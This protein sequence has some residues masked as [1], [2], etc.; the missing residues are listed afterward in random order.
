V[1]VGQEAGYRLSVASALTARAFLALD[2]G[3]LDGAERHFAASITLYEAIGSTVFADATRA[4]SGILAR[5]RGDTARAEVLLLRGLEQARVLPNRRDEAFLLGELALLAV[6][7]G[8]RQQAAQLQAEALALWRTLEHEPGIAAASSWLAATWADAGAALAETEALIRTALGLAARHRLAPTALMTFVS[9]ASHLAA[10]GERTTPLELLALAEGHP[11]ATFETRR[12]AAARTAELGVGMP[13]EEVA[14]AR[15]RGVNLDWRVLAQRF[16]SDPAGADTRHRPTPT[17]LDTQL[18]P[19][20]GRDYE[21]GQIVGLLSGSARRLITL[22]GPGGIGKTRLAQEAALAMLDSYADGV[23]FVALAPIVDPAQLVAAIAEP[24]GLRLSGAGEPRDQLLRLLSPKQ[25]LLLLDNFEQLLEGGELIPAILH[26]APKVTVLVTTRER[27]GLDGE[28]VYT[29]GGIEI[30]AGEDD[31][32]AMERGAVQ[33]LLERVRQIRPAFDPGPRDLDAMIRICQLVQGM[34]LALILAAS[35]ADMLSLREI[36]AEIERCLDFLEAD[37]R[38]LPPRQRSV[39][40]VFDVSWRRLTPMA[41][42]CFARMS[43]FRGGF[44]RHAAEQIVGTDLRMLRSLI[45]SSFIS[46]DRDNRYTVHEL[47]RQF[48][49]EHVVALGEAEALRDRHSIYYLDLLRDLEADLRRRRQAEAFQT[50]ESDLDNIRQAWGRAIE[51]QAGERISQAAHAVLLFGDKRGRFREG[52]DLL[53]QALDRLAPA[54]ADAGELWPRLTTRLS[55]LRSLFP[56]EQQVPMPE[57]E[58]CLALAQ[59]AGQVFEEALAY[60]ALGMYYTR[61]ENDYGQA[62]AQFEPAL[63]LLRALDDRF[64]LAETLARYGICRGYT[65]DIPG[66]YQYCREGCEIA[67]ADENGVG[68][69]IAQGNLMEALLHLGRY[70]EVAEYG[71]RQIALGEQLGARNGVAHALQFIALARFLEGD[72]DAA[73]QTAMRGYTLGAEI[74]N[75]SAMGTCLSILGLQASVSGDYPLGRRFA[76][77]A[78]AQPLNLL[79]LVQAHLGDAIARRGLGAH[80]DARRSLDDALQFARRFATSVPTLWLLP[81]AALLLADESHPADAATLLGLAHT[82]ELSPRGWFT[83]WRALAELRAGLEKALAPEEF[84]AAW[85]RGTQLEPAAATALLEAH[86]TEQP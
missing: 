86:V 14:A 12:R 37:L 20:I 6:D 55:L 38:A 13:P 56:R 41:Q 57:V 73:R 77:E 31:E 82:H 48:G 68:V 54:P 74:Q 64:H 72:L 59:Q 40:A 17:N 36:A 11:A 66:F 15:Q 65:G 75:A 39:R 83:R 84:A 47:L 2:V 52:A 24:L 33:L 42:V 46:P 35:W 80:A 4:Y 58:R 53:Q 51:Q 18:A 29:L 81:V 79:A 44:S 32:R 71:E 26:A 67:R 9:L 8:D 43:V 7:R 3:D 28:L 45:N 49:A 19:L 69:L 5:L 27:L 63:Q 16:S 34:P 70:A 25:L 61:T 23:F 85:G 60:F 76:A 50:I 78:L 62:L 21:L 10:Q 22:L 1:T 30:P